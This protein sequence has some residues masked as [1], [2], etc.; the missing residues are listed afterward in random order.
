VLDEVL[1]L[2]SDR[3]ML[4]AAKDLA[5]AKESLLRAASCLDAL[6]PQE[7][8]QNEYNRLEYLDN[9]IIYNESAL[10]VWLAQGDLQEHQ[11]LREKQK[12]L[13]QSRAILDA[14]L[15]GKELND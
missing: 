12:E 14:K 6:K 4:L 11:K 5:Q 7:E 15:S 9:Q 8:Q 1:V 2:E 10:A 3:A 13:V